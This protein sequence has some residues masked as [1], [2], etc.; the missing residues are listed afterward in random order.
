MKEER[1]DEIKKKYP[2]VTEL[3]EKTVSEIRALNEVLKSLPKDKGPEPQPKG[4]GDIPINTQWR[5]AENR[6]I[7]ERMIHEKQEFLLE[8]IGKITERVD[9]HTKQ[10]ID[11]LML[12]ELSRLSKGEEANKSEKESSI[13]SKKSLTDKLMES[14]PLAQYISAKEPITEEVKTVDK[15]KENSKEINE[16]ER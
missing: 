9:P 12:Y 2:E 6:I 4:P 3:V 11:S 10:S 7:Y 1:F 5:Q 8:G 15:F 16:P 14:T 13:D